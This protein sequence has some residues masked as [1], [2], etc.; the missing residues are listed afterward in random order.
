MAVY[1]GKLGISDA[2]AQIIGE[3]LEKLGGKFTPAEI[4]KAASSERSKL[5]RYFEWDDSKAA[6]S[7]RLHQARQLVER[8]K[9]V[10]HLNGEKVHTRAFHSVMVKIAGEEALKPRYVALRNIRQSKSLRDQV[11]AQA[12]KE[13]DG[14]RNRYQQY[15]DV[16]S[17]NL[18]EEIEAVLA[19]EASA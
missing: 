9:I 13:L 15:R 4:V 2:D 12:L 6:D 5:H 10:M 11:I 17:S 14:W 1:K 7:Y 19:K 8:V 16:L 18:F 3:E